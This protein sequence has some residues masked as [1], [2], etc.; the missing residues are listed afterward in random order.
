MCSA[1]RQEVHSS[2]GIVTARERIE[3]DKEGFDKIDT[4][5]M[6]V[7]SGNVENEYMRR[8]WF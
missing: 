7:L 3:M 5:H 6:P 2:A 4:S 1:G 8:R